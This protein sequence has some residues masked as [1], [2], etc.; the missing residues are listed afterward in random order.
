MLLSIKKHNSYSIKKTQA[1]PILQFGRFGIK[2]LSF[3]RLTENQFS[4]INRGLTKY[5]KKVTGGKK[6]TKLWTV[7]TL[8]L[9]LTKLSSESRMGKGKGSIYAKGVF[10]RPGDVIFEFEGISCQQMRFIFSFL[11]NQI[12]GKITTLVR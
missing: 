8:N 4:L 1:S 2:T 12:P 7:K 11:K 5:L 3:S 6:T 9:T 10:L